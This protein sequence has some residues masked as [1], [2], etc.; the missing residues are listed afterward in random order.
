MAS[1]YFLPSL[2]LDA[3]ERL[4]VYRESDALELREA[5]RVLAHVHLD[6]VPHGFTGVVLTGDAPFIEEVFEDALVSTYLGNGTRVHGRVPLPPLEFRP[7][8]LEEAVCEHSIRRRVFHPP[9]EIIWR[10]VGLLCRCHMAAEKLREL[11]GPPRG[12][13]EVASQVLQ[14]VACRRRNGRRFGEI[15]H[16]DRAISGGALE[17]GPTQLHRADLAH[18]SGAADLVGRRHR[19]LPFAARRRGRYGS[20]AALPYGLGLPRREGRIVQ[21]REVQGVS[22]EATNNDPMSPEQV[23]IE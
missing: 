5:E 19:H 14:A 10:V 2:R 6:E 21:A 11:L 15:G 17:D 7:Q 3:P 1:F 16:H 18:A 13:A 4:E 8:T 22:I 9:M 20:A 23:R 12:E